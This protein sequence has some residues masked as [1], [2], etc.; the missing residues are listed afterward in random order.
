MLRLRE[1]RLAKGMTQQEVGDYLGIEQGA[2]SKQEKGA[3]KIDTET[4]AKYAELYDVPVGHLFQDGDGLS[5]EERDLLNYIRAHP[6]DRAVLLSTYRGL[7]D[8]AR[9]PQYDYEN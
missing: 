7:R 8:N 5:A 3:T 6:R 4:L 9:T 2:V 1:L